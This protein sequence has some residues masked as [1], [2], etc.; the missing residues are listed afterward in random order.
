MAAHARRCPARKSPA[1]G[2]GYDLNLFSNF[3]YFLN[4]PVTATNWTRPITG[5]SGAL[6][7]AIGGLTRW[8][9]HSVQNTVG[10]QSATTTSQVGLYHTQAR[11]RLETRREAAVLETTAGVYG[12]N[13]TE[14]APWLRTTAGVRVDALAFA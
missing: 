11:V 5:S 1:F 6:R 4:D 13:E 10:V 14:W 2:L 8:A 3:T 12:Q 7:S 9:G